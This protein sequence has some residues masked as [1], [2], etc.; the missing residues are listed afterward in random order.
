MIL[1]FLRY[2]QKGVP[3]AAGPWQTFRLHNR[4]FDEL[5]RWLRTE[6]EDLWGYVEDKVRYVNRMGSDNRSSDRT[7]RLCTLQAYADADRYDYD[8]KHGILVSRMPSN[9]H[10]SFISSVS[11]EIMMRLRDIGR[12]GDPVSMAFAKD[13]HSAGCAWIDLVGTEEEDG[14]P[15]LR[16]SPDQWFRH[17]KAHWAGVI[18]ELS[19]PEK[20]RA[21][22][23]LADDYILDTDGNVRIVVG[24]DLDTVTKKATISTWRPLIKKSGNSEPDELEATLVIDNEVFRD[25]SGNPN[26]DPDAGLRLGLEDFA[27]TCLTEDLPPG[28][29]IFIDAKTLCQ[30]LSFAEEWDLMCKFPPSRSEGPRIRWRKRRFREIEPETPFS[31]DEAVKCKKVVADAAKEGETVVSGNDK[32]PSSIS[33]LQEENNEDLA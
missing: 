13:I 7:M 18:V 6:E 16:R 22:P 23:H 10:A 30:F 5:R 9:L 21:V 31:E 4:E 28:N 20:R 15:K 1:N 19:Y 11:S 8:S 26:P 29:S 32:M 27:P 12:G 17:R 2:R 25:E 14:K 33:T 24:F 3:F